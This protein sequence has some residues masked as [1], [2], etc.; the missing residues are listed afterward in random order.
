MMRL[1][2]AE[3]DLLQTGLTPLRPLRPES[4]HSV[5][6][7]SRRTCSGRA[8]SNSPTLGE[9]ALGHPTVNDVMLASATQDRAASPP[10]AVRNIPLTAPGT[11]LKIGQPAGLDVTKDGKTFRIELTVT[12]IA[13]ASK[14]DFANVTGDAIN[15]VANI[16]YVRGFLRPADSRN[17]DA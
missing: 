17:T 1:D 16:Y 11:V 10:P 9:T 8:Q 5:G 14:A 13:K 7:I 3:I 4:F 2:E 15:K 12:S 6:Q